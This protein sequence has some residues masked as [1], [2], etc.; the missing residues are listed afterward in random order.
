MLTI[1]QS[2]NRALLSSKCYIKAFAE[3]KTFVYVLTQICLQ[4]SKRLGSYSLLVF[5]YCLQ[6]SWFVSMEFSLYFN[7]FD[8]CFCS[9]KE[10]LSNIYSFLPYELLH[11]C[12]KAIV[13]ISKGMYFSI[14]IRYIPLVHI[15]DFLNSRYIGWYR[16]PISDT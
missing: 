3:C 10:T 9:D 7:Q 6:G 14:F 2:P 12:V 15:L 11:C 4:W 5:E 13:S 1:N 8:L 16:C